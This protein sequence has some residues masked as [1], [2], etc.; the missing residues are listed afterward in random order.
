[1]PK[2]TKKLEGNLFEKVHYHILYYTTA[3]FNQGGE[4]EDGEVTVKKAYTVKIPIKISADGDDSSA[5]VTTSEM[6][7]ISH[8]N[9]NLENVLE[10][11]SQLEEQVIKPKA[12]ADTGKRFRTKLKMLQLICNSGPA[13]QTL[14]EAMRKRR[15]FV[16]EEVVSTF[17]AFQTT[18]MR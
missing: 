7:W 6:K 15:E 16:V 4:L 11:L 18:M 14:Q 9:N 17:S 13:S 3:F 2:T 10:S 12:I 8:F 1:M 5:N